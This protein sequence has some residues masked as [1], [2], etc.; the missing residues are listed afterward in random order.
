[1]LFGLLNKHVYVYVVIG[2][3]LM[4]FP[5]YRELT[6]YRETCGKHLSLMLQ[7]WQETK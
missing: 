5:K 7:G 3:V 6:R 2:N 4:K 1:M